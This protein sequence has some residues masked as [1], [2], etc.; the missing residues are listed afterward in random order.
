MCGAVFSLL[1]QLLSG[2]S[3]RRLDS[4]TS[5]HDAS[6]RY[7]KIGSRDAYAFPD[8]L[9]GSIVRIDGR[10]PAEQLLAEGHAERILAIEHNRGIICSRLRPVGDRRI[11]LCSRHLP[12]APVELQLGTDAK[13]LGEIGRAHV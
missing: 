4:L 9:P 13:I 8:L 2:K 6:F 7:L 3:V 1:N 12:Y 11:V 10:L 5:T